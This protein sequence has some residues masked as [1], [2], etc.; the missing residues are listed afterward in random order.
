MRARI[1]L[2]FFRVEILSFYLKLRGLRPS[3]LLI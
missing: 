3:F 1:N 2:V